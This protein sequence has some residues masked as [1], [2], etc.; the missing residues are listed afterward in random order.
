MSNPKETAA[1]MEKASNEF[2][3]LDCL[4]INAGIPH[5]ARTEARAGGWRIATLFTTADKPN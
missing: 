2:G 3:R 4:V 5:V 1:L